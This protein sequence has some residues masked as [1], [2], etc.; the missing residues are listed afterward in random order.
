MTTVAIPPVS[1]Y[2]A[3][4]LDIDLGISQEL[5]SA[6][7][8]L[9]LYGNSGLGKSTNLKFAAKHYYAKSGKKVRLVAVEDSSK[10]IFEPL[11]RAGIVEAVFLTK[12]QNPL[13]TWRK[14]A[15]GEWPVFDDKGSVKEWQPVEKW[16]GTVSAYLI[17][18]GTSGSEQLLE[19]IRDGHFMMREQKSDAFEI[20]GE[21]F[22]AASQSAYGLVQMEMIKHLKA[23]GALPIERALWS[24]HEVKGVD[25]DNKEPIKGPG[26]V[27][28]A[29]TDA[30]QKYCGALLHIDGVA[31][32][33]GVIIP[34]IFFKRHKDTKF[35]TISYPAKT[36]IPIEQLTALDKLYPGGFFDPTVNGGLDKFLEVEEKLVKESAL[37]EAKWKAEID[38]KFSKQ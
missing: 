3:K 23:F 36:T 29:K 12:S 32:A 22:A 21:K 38:A 27:G 11:I 7:K 16:A 6:A 14:L 33:K 8:T 13:V 34:R 35:A 37:D 28:S 1:T 2:A 10:V 15:R 20:G 26:L 9:I 18:G 30:V 19:S 25:E 24:F 4:P 31:D 5:L 17:E